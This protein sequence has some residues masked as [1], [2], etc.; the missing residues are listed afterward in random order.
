MNTTSLVAMVMFVV[1]IMNSLLRGRFTL[2]NHQV[3]KGMCALFIWAA[4][5]LFLSKI[6]PAKAFPSDVYSY[7]WASG[8]SSPGMRGYSFLIRLF[9]S[10]MAINFIIDAVNTERRF[11]KALNFFLLFYFAV[12]L[13]V[14]AQYLLLVL[15][16]VQIGELRPS[17]MET[18]TRTGGYIGE[19]SNLAGLLVSGF[20]LTVA[21]AARRHARIWFPRWVLMAMCA[22]AIVGIIS[23]YSAAWILSAMLAAAVAGAKYLGR[24]ELSV[25][26][27][28]A[29]AVVAVFHAEIYETVF[30]KTFIQFSYI[31]VRSASW[32]AGLAIFLDNIQT[33]VG[34]GQSV[35]F[36]PTYLRDI[37]V[38]Y[39]IVPETFLSLFLAS[40]FPPMN[41]YI[42]WMAETG[43]VGLALLIYV[44][45]LVYRSGARISRPEHTLIV[46]FGLGAALM[47]T[48]VAANAA[49]DYLYVGFL[50]FLA[51]MYVAGGRLFARESS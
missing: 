36:A 1:F 9:L 38:N 13:Y 25:I 49:P 26:A 31:N 22:A 44:F 43:T 50:N 34:I 5:S 28:C 51:S 19:S 42:Q 30:R 11:F 40:R 12:C 10:M 29:I 4:V 45:Y 3:Q 37:A 46:K 6:D 32:T 15:L 21:F 18:L 23:T 33:G 35:F 14:L 20:F 7:A 17:A 39:F 2:A 41:T 8:L 16:G 27:V 24:K 47:A 48:V